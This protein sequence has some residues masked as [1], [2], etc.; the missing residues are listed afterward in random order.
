MTEWARSATGREAIARAVLAYDPGRSANGTI[1]PGGITNPGAD[2]ANNPTVGA[3]WALN[4]AIV[5]S[6]LG[7]QI[8][9]RVDNV[10]AGIDTLLKTTGV[11][12][13]Q[14]VNAQ[15]ALDA[16]GSGQLSPE[17][18]A[19]ALR[20]ALGDEQAASVGRLLAS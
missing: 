13:G 8:R 17:E 3:N 11:A 7:Y 18:T 19:A 20:A 4:R 16:I 5:A 9:D 15:N 14:Q 1:P 12:V 6:V 2:A 10:Q